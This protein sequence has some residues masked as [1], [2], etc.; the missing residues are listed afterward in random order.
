MSKMLST[1][2]TDSDPSIS[3]QAYVRAVSVGGIKICILAVHL[4]CIVRVHALYRGSQRAEWVAATYATYVVTDFEH[5]LPKLHISAAPCL[6]QTILS[7][8][9]QKWLPIC[10]SLDLAMSSIFFLMTV[11]KLRDS[12]TDRHGKIRYDILKDVSY[13]NPLLTV[14]VVDGAF[15]FFLIVGVIIL[16]L[17]LALYR[18]AFYFTPCWPWIYA[19]L[20]SAGSHLVLNLR[21][22]GG[23]GTPTAIFGGGDGL[24][25]PSIRFYHETLAESA[26]V[27]NLTVTSNTEEISR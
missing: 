25:L 2:D 11:Y 23:Q 26:Q 7:K 17:N 6:G 12:L 16:G 9:Q 14:L 13:I 22:M 8:R 18:G 3:C 20:S 10:W 19:V 21:R 24:T 1:P 15:A 5:S 4:I 27:D